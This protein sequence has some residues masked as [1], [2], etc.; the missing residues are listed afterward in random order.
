MAPRSGLSPSLINANYLRSN[1]GVF[2]SAICRRHAA[3]LGAREVGHDEASMP[4]VAIDGKTLWHSF[5][6]FNDRKANSRSMTR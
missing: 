2:I 6:T 3:G 4:V 1:R 5:D